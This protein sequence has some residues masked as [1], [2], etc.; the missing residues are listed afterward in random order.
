MWDARQDP[1]GAV[2]RWKALVVVKGLRELDVP[3]K[4]PLA[5]VPV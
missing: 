4:L 2:W 5:L 3:V 1:G